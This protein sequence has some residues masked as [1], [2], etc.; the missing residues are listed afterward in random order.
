M[1]GSPGEGTCVQCH[2]SFGLNAGDGSV[3]LK[4]TDLEAN[5]WKFVGGQTYDLELTISH[6]G[7]TLFGFDL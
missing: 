2:N 7:A 6:I 1:T 5:N 3:S 4:N